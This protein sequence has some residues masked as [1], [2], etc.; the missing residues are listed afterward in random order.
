MVKSESSKNKKLTTIHRP[1]MNENHALEFFSTANPV[2][3]NKDL[4]MAP[5]M[6]SKYFRVVYNCA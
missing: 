3:E 6:I 4:Q 2:V 5:P 1:T